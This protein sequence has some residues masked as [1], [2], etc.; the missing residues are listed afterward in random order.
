VS[1]FSPNKSKVEFQSNKIPEGLPEP[2]K[3]SESHTAAE[4]GKAISNRV[5]QDT[6]DSDFNFRLKSTADVNTISEGSAGTVRDEPDR[7]QLQSEGRLM[8]A[9]TEGGERLLNVPAEELFFDDADLDQ[10]LN[11]IASREE[12]ELSQMTV[13]EA[14]KCEFQ[15]L[16]ALELIKRV[17]QNKPLVDTVRDSRLIPIEKTKHLNPKQNKSK[18]SR[19]EHSFIKLGADVSPPKSV[20]SNPFEAYIPPHFTKSLSVDHIKTGKNKST[21]SVASSHD[22]KS[23][24]D[25]SHRLQLK[26]IQKKSK[27]LEESWSSHAVKLKS[28]R[29]EKEQKEQEKFRLTLKK[30]L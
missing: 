20:L 1:R 29:Q 21:D 8:T 26:H 14:E 25:I 17:N 10:N 28:I 6:L 13:N 23:F 19:I 2:E 24:D 11:M 16:Q 27:P 7:S 18:L 15:R 9:S 30:Y 12:Q 3:D 22:G 5:L 4:G